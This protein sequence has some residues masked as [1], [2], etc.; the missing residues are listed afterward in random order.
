MRYNNDLYGILVSVIIVFSFPMIL[1]GFD[2]ILLAGNHRLFVPEILNEGDSAT[3]QLRKGWNLISLC[4]QPDDT[5]ITAILDPIAGKHISAWTYSASRNH[6]KVYNPV[7]PGFSDLSTMEAGYAYWLNMKESAT[8]AISGSKPSGSVPLVDGWNLIGYNSSVVKSISDALSSID[9]RY[10]IVWAY[11]GGVW[12][13]Y[14]LDI[15]L[16][17][18]MQCCLWG[19]YAGF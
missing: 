5:G 12:L 14:V 3:I 11:K 15:F 10:R 8:L 6:W 1:N 19:L 16:S 7:Q 18:Y 2:E 17:G 9:G 4:L 13:K